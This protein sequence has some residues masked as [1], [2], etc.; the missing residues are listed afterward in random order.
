MKIYAH[1]RFSFYPIFIC[2]IWKS[3]E[4]FNL[5]LIRTSPPSLEFPPVPSEAAVCCV[6]TRHQ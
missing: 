6:P 5:Y 3:N 2:T 4:A 1:A